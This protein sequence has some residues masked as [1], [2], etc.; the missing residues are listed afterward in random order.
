MPEEKNLKASS[1]NRHKGCRRNMLGQTVRYWQW[2]RPHTA[3]Q[4]Q[5]HKT[6]HAFR[7]WRSQDM[8]QGGHETKRK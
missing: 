4:S 6:L 2:K 3:L 1:E 7:H 8:V 5:L